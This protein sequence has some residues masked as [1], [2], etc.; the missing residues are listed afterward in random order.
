MLISAATTKNCCHVVVYSIL[1]RTTRTN[2]SITCHFHFYTLPEKNGRK[3][4]L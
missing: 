1:S 4:A 3:W 2:V